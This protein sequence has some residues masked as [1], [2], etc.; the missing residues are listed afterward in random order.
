MF[1][2][3]QSSPQLS[4]I[5]HPI[6]ISHATFRFPFHS[7]FLLKQPSSSLVNISF[8]Y[9]QPRR[10]LTWVNFRDKVPS[11][12]PTNRFHAIRS[13]ESTFLTCS[14]D[15]RSNLWVYIR[16]CDETSQE[17]FGYYICGVETKRESKGGRGVIENQRERAASIYL[18]QNQSPTNEHF[19][20]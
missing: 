2:Y 5:I 19:L 6:Y 20:F 17:Q 3:S 7:S 16:L 4:I 11:L 9:Q 15:P 13:V 18:L 10:T 8:R 1:K 14:P 12:P